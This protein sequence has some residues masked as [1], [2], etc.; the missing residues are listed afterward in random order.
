M[1]INRQYYCLQQ[2]PFILAWFLFFRSKSLKLRSDFRKKRLLSAIRKFVQYKFHLAN[3]MSGLQLS[4]FGNLCLKVHRGYRLF[5][6]GQNI[7]TKFFT[8]DVELSLALKELDGARKAGQLSFAPEILGWSVKERW[9]QEELVD[10]YIGY[11]VPKSDS[12]LLLKMFY[13]DI[14]PCIEQMI[15]FQP[16]VKTTVGERLSKCKRI[17]DDGRLSRPELHLKKVNEIRRFAETVEYQLSLMEDNDIYL[18]FSHGDFSLRNMLSTRNG[19]RVIDWEGVDFRTV[20]FDLYNCFFT[21]SYYRRVS[22]NLVAEIKESICF[23]QNRLKKKLPKVVVTL[24]TSVEQYRWLYY[25]ERICMLLE[26][27]LDNK[28]LGVISRS[29]AVFT[30]HEEILRTRLQH[31][32]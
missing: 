12:G 7:V 24:D 25:L 2:N 30:R 9:Y 29:I 15:L 11:S 21:E 23:L 13:R 19:L 31:I 4:E 18:V 20:L 6:F 22:T 26:R 32:L 8:P 5:N 16:A 14:A 1:E 17:L 27:E 10:G 28:I 3:D